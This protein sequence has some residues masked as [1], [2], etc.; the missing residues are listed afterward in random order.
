MIQ[1]ILFDMDGVLIDT[2]KYLT[3]FWRQ[4]AAEYGIVITEEESYQY[5]SF[6]SKFAAPFFAE[7]HGSQEDYRKI[8][9]RRKEI[10]KG[11]LEKNGLEKKDGVDEVLPKLKKMGYEIAVVTATDEERAKDYL[12]KIGIYD[13]FDDVICATMVERGKPYPD[14]YLYA[15][16]RIGKKTSEC[17]AVED[18]PNGIRAA[19]TAGCHVVMIPDLTQPDE[20]TKK[21]LDYKADSIRDI[22]KIVKD[23]EKTSWED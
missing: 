1:A 19:Y 16:E 22:P 11:H 4:A 5:R 12:T 8:R 15:C 10:M 3:K 14:V 9:A 17:I 2:E 20:E 23:W 18:S 7:K 6:A 21:M 13:F